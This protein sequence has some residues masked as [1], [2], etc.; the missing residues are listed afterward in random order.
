M[1]PRI[2]DTLRARLERFLR[3]AGIEIAGI[4]FATGRDGMPLVYDVNTNTNYNASAEAAAEIKLTGM[5]AIANFL[6][7]ELDKLGLEAA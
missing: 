4:E 7:S 3:I 2:D 6:Q 1:I 5:R